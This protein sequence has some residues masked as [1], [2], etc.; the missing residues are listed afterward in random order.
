[1]SLY[2]V[3]PVAY[4]GYYY[5]SPNDIDALDFFSKLKTLGIEGVIVSKSFEFLFESPLESWEEVEER[6][7]KRS[8]TFHFASLRGS[9]E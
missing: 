6:R 5:G 7:T 8:R 1:M 3:L 2:K 4:D 9:D